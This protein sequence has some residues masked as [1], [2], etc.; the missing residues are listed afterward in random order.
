MSS[1]PPAR[2]VL[3]R[4][5][6][7]L[8]GYDLDLPQVFL[9]EARGRVRHA[10]R[11]CAGF[12]RQFRERAELGRSDAVSDDMHANADLRI[13]MFSMLYFDLAL[14]LSDG[15]LP[16]VLG[17][18]QGLLGFYCD[19][20]A[21]PP[22]PV[23][24]AMLEELE[25]LRERLTPQMVRRV[26]SETDFDS[27]AWLACLEAFT[28]GRHEILARWKGGS[29]T[30][31]QCLSQADTWVAL[32]DP[33]KPERPEGIATA[34]NTKK[35]GYLAP[36]HIAL[37]A[38]DSPDTPEAEAEAFSVH[39]YPS[40]LTAL[41]HY[42]SYLSVGQEP[43]TLGWW[44]TLDTAEAWAADHY[45]AAL[46]SRNDRRGRLLGPHVAR[47]DLALPPA[48][49]SSDALPQPV[50]GGSHGAAFSLCLMQAIARAHVRN[51]V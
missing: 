25:C 13:D 26:V 32:V 21:L 39:F 48:L 28:P 12:R 44:Q 38:V 17:D 50:R 33:T 30:R 11:S 1:N 49:A 42:S 23:L 41:D 36:L 5:L 27:E 40:L 9:D 8:L 24:L 16:S 51:P 18:A 2:T 4:Y 43:G 19:D 34:T 29:S 46:G 14:Q 37:C 45:A 35:Q 6:L 31:L 7:T 47:W 15:N 10:L 22:R 3:L 20:A